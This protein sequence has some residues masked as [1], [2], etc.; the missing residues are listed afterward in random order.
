[1]TYG[2]GY[3]TAMSRWTDGAVT[4]EE[5]VACVTSGMKIFVHGAAATPTPLLE[6]LARRHN[7]SGVTLYHLH[8][9]GPAPFV[10]PE[11][12]GRFRSVSAFAGP[13]VRA[14]KQTPWTARD[15]SSTLKGCGSYGRR[16]GSN[17]YCPLGTD[18]AVNFRALERELVGERSKWP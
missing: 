7:L 4:S 13:P 3:S 16:M 2:A 5:A 11:H 12:R 17:A 14:A 6:A 18:D 10:D 1:M 8:T 15:G 9:S